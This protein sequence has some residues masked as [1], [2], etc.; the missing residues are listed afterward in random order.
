MHKFWSN[1]IRHMRTNALSHI[2]HIHALT[3]IQR[4]YIHMIDW[5][6]YNYLP[7]QQRRSLAANTLRVKMLKYLKQSHAC[8]IASGKQCTR[9]AETMLTLSASCTPTLV[10]VRRVLP[11]AGCWFASVHFSF[12]YSCNRYLASIY[13]LRRY[14]CGQEDIC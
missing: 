6:F 14:Y 2:D 7:R 11:C 10:H 5:L 8:I 13:V 4:H 1:Y 9:A 3:L 12:Y